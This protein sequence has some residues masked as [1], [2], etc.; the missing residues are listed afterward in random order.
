MLEEDLIKDMFFEDGFGNNVYS[1][2]EER[3]N[4][5]RE[6][7][8][9]L[10]LSRFDTRHEEKGPIYIKYEYVMFLGHMLISFRIQT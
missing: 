10:R 4:R 2:L 7:L 1:N 5:G 8:R 3:E 6:T 9:R